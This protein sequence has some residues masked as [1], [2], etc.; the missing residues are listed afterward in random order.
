MF[1]TIL[2]RFLETIPVM[3]IIVTLAFFMMRL[4]PGNPFESEK[5][6]T[7]EVRAAMDAQYGLD[8]PLLVQYLNYWKGLLQLDLGPSYQYQGWRVSELIGDKI[9]VSLELGMYA[10]LIALGIGITAGLLAAWKPNTFSDYIP[11][12]F[13]MTGICLPAFVLGPLF[14]LVFALKLNWF[15]VSGWFL[16]QDRILPAFTLG[17]V[18]A[19][20]IAR[21]TRGSMVEVRNQ[22]FMRTAAAKGLPE[23]RVYVVHGL[24]N[25]L[26]PVVSYLGPLVAHLITGSFVIE[27]IFNI[28]GLGRFFVSSALNRDDTMVL[29]TVI[30]FALLLIALNLVVDLILVWLDPRRKLE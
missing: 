8:K 24:R 7:P 30:F 28:P 1:T 11:M 25:G 12:G 29:G 14:V 22:D 26:S 19:A 2:R 15:N 21:L 5:G 18:Y 27:T 6:L 16:A 3:F 10:L 4:A 23:W 20:T 9:V 17:I 13:A